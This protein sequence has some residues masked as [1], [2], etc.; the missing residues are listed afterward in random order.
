[1]AASVLVLVKVVGL[2]SRDE[3]GEFTLVLGANILDDG[4]GSGLL[5]DKG[6]DAGLALDDHVGDTHLAAE[7]GQEDDKLDG[8]DVVGDDNEVS[9]LGLDEGNT[10]VE[11][12]L[13]EKGLLAIG[14]R[15]SLLA[16]GNLLGNSIQ[17]GLLLL[18]A[19][20]AV[21]VHELEQSSSSVLVEGV[22]ELSDG[23]RHLE[24]LVE[25]DLL[26]L[27]A[28]VFG[29]LHKAGQVTRRL[30][31]LTCETRR[32][33]ASQSS[34]NAIA[35]GAMRKLTDAEATGGLLEERV[36]HNLL[37]ATLGA[38]VR[39]GGGLLARSSLGSLGL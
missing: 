35:I 15:V 3:V 16:V 30:D 39:R 6:T 25:D 33:K 13:D 26:A 10:V 34:T 24:A 12:V 36:L 37:R 27:K 32:R 20:G 28:D 22:R 21:L 1:M 19:L 14:L 8:V 5:V 31:V 7:G 18:L 23:R 4:D 38:G 29:P 17:A 9:L 2:G 11:T